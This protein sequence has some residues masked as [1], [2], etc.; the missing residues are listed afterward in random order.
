[1]AER[2]TLTPPA[3]CALWR[4]PELIEQRPWSEL[5][6]H[7]ETFADAPHWW[8]HLLRC[9]ECGQRYFY[10]FYEE[11]DWEDGGDP[12]Y[13]TLVGITAEDDIEA[14]KATNWL[15][16]LGVTPRLQIDFPKDA[17]KPRI[18][19]IRGVWTNTMH[20]VGQGR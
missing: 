15:T 14:L 13:K 5:F 17:D 19:W 16:L 6:E 8:R 3:R 20:N 12:Q 11:I 10:E 7:L 9:R 4:S 1:M 18:R 2:M